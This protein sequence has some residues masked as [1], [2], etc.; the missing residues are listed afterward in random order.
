MK[1]CLCDDCAR[2]MTVEEIH[3]YGSRCE[4]CEQAWSDRMG[5]W[6]R[7][8]IEEPEMDAMFSAPSKKGVE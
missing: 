1:P 6:M 7:R 8:E 3:Y 5:A 4:A 2:P